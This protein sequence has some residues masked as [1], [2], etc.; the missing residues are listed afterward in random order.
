MKVSSKIM[1]T[2]PAPTTTPLQARPADLTSGATKSSLKALILDIAS[3]LGTITA[4]QLTCD[5]G[6]VCKT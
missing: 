2:A 4:M 3:T 5:A 6:K 1:P